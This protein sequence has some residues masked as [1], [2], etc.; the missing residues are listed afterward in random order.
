MMSA[1]M[2]GKTSKLFGR[3]CLI[4]Y[5]FGPESGDWMLRSVR[6]ELN[7]KA[8]GLRLTFVHGWMKRYK[9]G[10][11]GLARLTNMAWVYF[12]TPLAILIN[13][14][15]V[16]LVRSSPPGVQLWV[17]FWARFGRIPVIVWLM[18]YHP[19]IEA[20][21]LEVR[22]NHLFAGALRRADRGLL[23]GA[24]GVVVLDEAMRRLVRE[25]VPN[26]GVIVHPTW[27]AEK[28]YSPARYE[29]GSDSTTRRLVYA[30][31]LGAAHQMGALVRLVLA[32]R[33][34]GPVELHLIGV[35]AADVVIRCLAG[36]PV[37]VKKYPWTPFGQLG[38]RFVELRVDLGIV[39][40]R[41]EA[42][43]VVSPSK[44]SGYVSHGLP[45][46][47]V[48]PPDTTACLVC[49]KFDAGFHLENDVEAG[50]ADILATKVWDQSTLKRKAANVSKAAAHFLKQDGG[51][52]AELV[53]PFL[54]NGGFDPELEEDGIADS[55]GAWSQIEVAGGI[56][57]RDSAAHVVFD[58]KMWVIGGWLPQRGNDVWASA[59]GVNW[60]SIS[61]QCPWDARN[62]ASAVAFK[63]RLWLLAGNDSITSLNDVWS[64][65]D[66]R[67]WQLETAH[68]QW[69]PRCATSVLVF[70]DRLWIFGGMLNGKRSLDNLHF[71]DI[72]SSGD[73]VDWVKEV[74]HAPWGRRAMHGGL[75]FNG[76]LWL[77]GGG[78]YFNYKSNFADV[79]SSDNG[80]DWKCETCLS[81]WTPRRF[82][83]VV[84]W[85]E[86]I[87]LV[88]G[89][90][91]KRGQQ[92]NI[93]DMWS[94]RDGIS[95]VLSSDPIP[96]SP[97]H[98]PALFPLRD[99]LVMFGGCSDN[100]QV[101]G[102]AW[103][104]S[105]ES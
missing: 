72:W 25:R 61:Q 50:R 83:S 26:V 63:G 66:G 28:Q 29:P 32:L 14:P 13:R 42:A 99:R 56:P 97:R 2:L 80:R 95:W 21:W 60:L 75:V 11:L 65:P 88:G 18:D 1:K 94:S 58:A 105:V 53:L 3:R 79:W 55:G 89:V 101:C 4:V 22:G 93:S 92:R 15:Y 98:A 76:R 23:A 62:L 70:R 87:W 12:L 38:E 43:G 36:H 47:Y 5:E 54:E 69:Q 96:W 68:A 74:E 27:G 19:E 82:H 31:N 7:E 84:A 49:T 30:G 48:G 73:G 10:G 78:H 103:S 37:L 16:I 81:P 41:N 77:V 52:F 33:Q 40:L 102:D 104:Y 91:F 8:P 39:L 57:S 45:L 67:T 34:V 44:F 59:D 71:D 17:L 85:N 24:L 46:I 51:S 20:R 90:N 64:S 100:D 6:D 9:P 86:R 35:P